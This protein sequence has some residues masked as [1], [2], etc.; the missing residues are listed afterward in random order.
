MYH[1]R[2]ADW[3][4]LTPEA[5]DGLVEEALDLLPGWAQP[6][7]QRVAVMVEQ[8][9]PADEDPDL[10]GL[11]VGATVF[12]E[13]DSTSLGAT[14][15]TVLIFQ[16]PHERQARSRTELFREVAETVLH[17]IAHHF[18]LEEEALERIGPLR[19]TPRWDEDPGENT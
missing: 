14:P 6:Y 19:T 3:P 16:G 5:F 18:G 9:P 8:E 17:E 11:Y 2:L 7:L 13:P 12:G 4:A 1:R 10:L 15:D